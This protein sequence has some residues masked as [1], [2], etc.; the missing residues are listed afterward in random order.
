MKPYLSIALLVILSNIIFGQELA[1]K[2]A[3]PINAT[4]NSN[5]ANLNIVSTTNITG[6]SKVEIFKEE[7]NEEDGPEW[8]YPTFIK[9]DNYSFSTKFG[10][11]H[12]IKIQDIAGND[13]NQEVIIATGCYSDGGCGEKLL[14]IRTFSNLPFSITDFGEA[15]IIISADEYY[16]DLG[17]SETRYP[18][19][20][21]QTDLQAAKKA[22]EFIVVSNGYDEKKGTC[23][24]SLRSYKL[25]TNGFTKGVLS[26][27]ITTVCAG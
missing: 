1:F 11:G 21:A 27:K 23:Y 19:S 22:G 5:I 7:D 10:L 26:K 2:K 12:S 9:V 6:T 14:I 18:R 4:F 15:K 24:F 8:S 16:D 3:L 17:I 20:V 13:N 25:S